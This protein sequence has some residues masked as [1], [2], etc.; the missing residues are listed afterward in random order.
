MW[1]ESVGVVA[2]RGLKAELNL[3]MPEEPAQLGSLVESWL[4][5]GAW[6]TPW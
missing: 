1:A 2:R 3:R 6:P 4:M 5:A